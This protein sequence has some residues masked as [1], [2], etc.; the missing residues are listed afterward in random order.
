[1]EAINLPNSIIDSGERLSEITAAYEHAHT[2]SRP[3]VVAL[4]RAVLRGEA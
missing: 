4:T 2:I 3:R 1:M